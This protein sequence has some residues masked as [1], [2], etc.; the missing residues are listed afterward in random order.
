MIWLTADTH[1]AHK[2]ICEYS[3]R[4]FG[5]VEEM[6][7][8]LIEN[9]NRVIKSKDEVW[10]LGDFV[11]SYRA[12]PSDYRKRL[13]GRI[14]LVLGNHDDRKKLDGLFESIQDVKYLRINGEKIWLS[15]YAHRTWPKSHRGSFHCHGHSHGDL[16]K[17]GRSMDV[18][19]DANDYHPIPLEAVLDILRAESFTPHHRE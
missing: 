13:N 11:V 3:S 15:H 7:A 12:Q 9:W 10:H 17:W 16:P 14:N 4:P 18:G 2:R 6:D 19:V 8:I 5:S 1:F